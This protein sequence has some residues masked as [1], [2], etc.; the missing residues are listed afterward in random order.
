MNLLAIFVIYAKNNQM[1]VLQIP[2]TI[3]ANDHALVFFFH[4]I[5]VLKTAIYLLLKISI[6]YDLLSTDSLIILNGYDYNF[7]ALLWLKKCN[8]LLYKIFILSFF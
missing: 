4:G 3:I 8:C 5:L 7:Y 1:Q 6:K 2:I